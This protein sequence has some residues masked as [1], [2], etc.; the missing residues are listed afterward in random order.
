[1]SRF[2]SLWPFC[3]VRLTLSGLASVLLTVAAISQEVRPPKA[4]VGQWTIIHA[5]T[6]LAMPGRA[7]KEHQSIVIHGSAITEIRDGFA[8]ARDIKLGDNEVAIVDLSSEFV[9]PGLI[10]VHTHLIGPESLEYRH[11]DEHAVEISDADYAFIATTHARTVLEHGF[12]TVRNVGASFGLDYALKKAI[13]DGLVL[14]PRMQVSGPPIGPTGTQRDPEGYRKEI[15]EILRR[16]VSLGVCDGPIDCRQH[17]RALVRDGADLVKIKASGGVR[18]LFPGN[19][20]PRLF[21]DELRALVETAHSLGRKVASHAISNASIKASL[22][23]GVDSIEHGSVV[24]D[25]AVQLF[26]K[27]GAYYVPTLLAPTDWAAGSPPAKRALADEIVRRTYESIAR[28]HK[29]GVK[30]A[31][32]SDVGFSSFDRGILELTLLAKAGLAPMEVLQAA[33]VNGADLMGL[34]GQIGT[35]QPGKRADI[36]ACA[37][38]PLQKIDHILDIDFVMKSGLIVRRRP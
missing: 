21:D 9:L 22:R 27:T 28:A 33:T 14:G 6:L 13:D 35:L 38:N 11:A 8:A 34:G 10:D 19:A 2:A 32:G 7:P 36:V 5:G 12:T 30:F 29:A 24:D 37:G 20:D 16:G 26:L 4:P 3:G 15:Q 1:M 23:A 25:E 17:V 31:T 18:V